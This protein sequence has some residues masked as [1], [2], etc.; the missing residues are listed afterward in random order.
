MVNALDLDVCYLDLGHP[1]S[2][3]EFTFG[4]D[5]YTDEWG[6]NYRK[7]WI[8]SDNFFYEPCDPPLYNAVKEDLDIYPWPD[9]Y[10]PGW[11]DGLAE[12][13][14][15][16]RK[17]L[18]RAII[19][20]LPFSIFEYAYMLRGFQQF[21]LDLKLSPQFATALLDRVCDIA[22]TVTKKAVHVAGEHI[23]LVKHLDDQGTQIGT[24]L[25]PNMFRE[26]IRPRFE[27]LYRTIKDEFALCNPI[28]KVMTHT[29]GDI[30]PLIEDYII[31]GL[32]ILNPLQP[33][34]G[35]M[36]HRRIKKEFGDKLAFHGGVD[37]Q[38]VMPFG[39]QDEVIAD[40]R[41]CIHD[42]APGGGY[43]L[44]PCHVLQH[45]VLPVNIV[46]LRDAVRKYGRY[47]LSI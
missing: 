15:R 47:P 25:S 42:L 16:L 43:I 36:D 20:E 23:D 13:A 40:V 41:R 12:R 2:V 7:V 32:D 10:D 38:S 27:R 6:V 45:D 11:V 3:P 33:G 26:M 39:T 19:L 29:C 4:M 8:S 24:L 21:L 14:K 44:A 22:V 46:A 5:Y 28:G 34:V 37:V 30:Y 9:P 18:G 17:S 35:K 1:F 31:A